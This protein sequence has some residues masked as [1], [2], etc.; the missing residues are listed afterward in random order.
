VIKIDIYH[1]QILAY[2]LEKL[3]SIREGDGSLLDRSMIL[4]GSGLSD[5]NLHLHD[6]LPVLLVNGGAGQ[7]KGGR[8]IRY[9]QGTPMANLYLTI[10]ERLGVSQESL[11]DSTGKLSLSV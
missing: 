2:Y 9:P 5:G 4:Y 10:L 8:H 7:V 3:R 6:N 1:T 11:G